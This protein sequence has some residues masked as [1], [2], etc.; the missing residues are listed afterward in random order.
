M[1]LLATRGVI[2][3]VL[4]MTIIVTVSNVAVQVPIN[5]WL[6]WRGSGNRDKARR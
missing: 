3:G 6:T 5:D 4:A 1:N 2:L